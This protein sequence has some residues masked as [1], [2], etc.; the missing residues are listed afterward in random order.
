MASA[1]VSLS[2]SNSSFVFSSHLL[3]LQELEEI[4]TLSNLRL[5]HL[6]AEYDA[7]NDCLIFDRKLVDGPVQWFRFDGGQIHNQKHE[8]C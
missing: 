7:E 1:L 2:Q 6:R 8:I 3:N 5:A 4:K